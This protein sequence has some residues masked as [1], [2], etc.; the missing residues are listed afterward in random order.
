M[1]TFH[2]AK[3]GKCAGA[4]AG[5]RQQGHHFVSDIQLR[6]QRELGAETAARISHLGKYYEKTIYH[7]MLS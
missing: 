1:E 6:G 4:E 2:L 7:L 3:K 5:E